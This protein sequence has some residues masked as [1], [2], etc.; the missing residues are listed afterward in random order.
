MG[1]IVIGAILGLFLVLL[2]VVL[3]LLMNPPNKWVQRFSKEE[4]DAKIEQ[5][6]R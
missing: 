1:T 6:R 2:L 3:V 4:S 5:E